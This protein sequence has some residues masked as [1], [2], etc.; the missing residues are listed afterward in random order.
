MTPQELR[1]QEMLK[2]QEEQQQELEPG[3]GE[4][5]RV[6]AESRSLE[7]AMRHATTIFVGRH[8]SYNRGSGLKPK[9][10]RLCRRSIHLQIAIPGL[11]VGNEI[12]VHGLPVGKH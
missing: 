7:A 5:N 3:G 6:I 1:E 2:Q 9:P 8:R 4:Q 10:S 11:A 12:A